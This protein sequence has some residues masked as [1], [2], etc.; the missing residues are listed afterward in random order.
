MRTALAIFGGLVLMLSSLP[1]I[2]AVIRGETK[3]RIV[4][5]FTWTLLLLV[6]IAA[7]AA[8]HDWVTVL[9]LGGDAV[10][11]SAIVVFGW[12]YGDRRFERFDVV[13]Q[14]AAIVGLLLWFVFDSPLVAVVASVV[15]DFIGAV[16]S[17]KHSWQEP[18]E[19]TASTFV[20]D[21]FGA[22][23][24]L[25]AL[26]SFRATAVVY[27]IY[28]VVINATFALIV[29]GRRKYAVAGEPAELREL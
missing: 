16:P 8:D 15:I 25:A 28:L 20:M 6:S 7:T 18:Y 27:P 12:K 2:R 17:I 26:T 13:C 19:E 1:Y 3:P 22:L 21:T 14:V 24:S 9:L 11:T 29:V 10:G 4:S 5:W 23:A